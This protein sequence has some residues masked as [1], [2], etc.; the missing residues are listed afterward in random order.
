MGFDISYEG[1]NGPFL[2]KDQV[3]DAN[4]PTPPMDFFGVRRN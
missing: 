1:F 4:A 3:Y 2:P